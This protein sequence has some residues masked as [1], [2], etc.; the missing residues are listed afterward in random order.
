MSTARY[1]W[2]IRLFLV[3]AAA[4]ALALLLQLNLTRKIS[5][6]VLDLIPAGEQ[7][8]ELAMVRA[9]AGEERARV[10][11]FA[12][13]LPAG[14]AAR[15]QVEETFVNG[16]RGSGAFADAVPMADRSAREEL[17]RQL[18]AQRL[19]LLLA[20]WLANRRDEYANAEPGVDWAPWLAERTASSLEAFLQR[21]EALGFQDLLPADPLL[22]LPGLLEILPALPDAAPVADGPVLVWARTQASPL[23]EQGQE[24]VFAAVE[25]SL[26]EVRTLE[27]GAKLQ[28]SSIARFAAESRKRIRAELAWL[29][30]LSLAAVFAVGAAGLRQ[31]LRTAHLVPIVLGGLLGAW[32]VTLLSFERVHVLVFVV[33]SLLAGVAVDY[34]LHLSL[35]TADRE[36]EPYRAH[37]RRVLKPLLASALTTIVGF[38]MLLFSELPLIRQLGVFVSAG[39]L[40]SLATALLWFAQLQ[41][42]LI[43]TRAMTRAEF[44]RGRRATRVART[45]LA[46]VGMVA[47]VGPWTLHWHDD[48]RELEIPAPELR[49]EATRVQARFGDA[50][51]RA[52]YLTQGS[53]PRVARAA[54]AEFQA[55]HDAQ[56]PDAPLASLALAVPTEADYA[57]VPSRL[58]GLREFLP[59]LRDALEARG[60]AAEAFEPFF[61]EWS[62]WVEQPRRDYDA[63]VGRLAEAL[64]GPLS[65]M[66][67]V[68][69]EACWFV[70]VAEHGPAADPP[71]GLSTVSVR[72]LENLNR[73]FS[74]YRSSAL[75]LSSLGLIVLGIG[76]IALYGLRTGWR[77]F[78]VPAIACLFAFGLLGLAGQ[79]LNL[80]H[81][82]GAFLGVCLSHDY[83]IFSV[84]S[85][86]RQQGPPVSVRLSALTTSASFGVLSLSQIPVVSA[87]GVTVALIV[88][89]ALAIVELAP[90]AR[91]AQPEPDTSFS[92]R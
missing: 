16:L 71:A 26:A 60:F 82:L 90:L 33:G 2:G 49:A 40:C 35:R 43:E 73:L 19:D 36:D 68:S 66:L 62:S 72:Q 44:P 47:V 78:V 50:P 67:S 13:E 83:A 25:R 24:P 79:T 21:P 86:S 85:M 37:V 6:D 91:A 51:D 58:E 46:L 10:A 4:S 15:S 56:H 61:Q 76:V 75:A 3:V 57:A 18:F 64:H 48:I 32:T 8:P 89:A 29:N 77:I 80:F 42:P 53:N 45:I 92:P 74:R 28:W 1:V 41:R 23:T 7:D 81:L 88:L 65:L 70:S 55:W 12:L 11:L 63:M 5:T 31:V 22:L 69:S 27:P 52:M 34:G 9:L 59:R 30:L 17:A 20:A 84:E 54:F 87:L 14:S 39:L 38:S